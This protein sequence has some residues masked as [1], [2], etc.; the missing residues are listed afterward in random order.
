MKVLGILTPFVLIALAVVVVALMKRAKATA[1]STATTNVPAAPTKRRSWGWIGWVVAVLVVFW[2][3]GWYRSPKT[4]TSRL[5]PAQQ[6]ATTTFQRTPAPPTIYDPLING[7]A[8]KYGVPADLIRSVIQRESGFNPKAVSPKGAKGLMQLMD[9][10]AKTYGV[11][12]VF[13][14][15]QNIDAGVHHLS[16]LLKK[17]GQTEL[18]LATYNSNEDTVDRVRPRGSETFTQISAR[19]PDE[20]QKYV[21]AVMLAV[22]AYQ[23]GGF[24]LTVLAKIGEWSENVS[25]PPFHWAR[26]IPEGKIRI[27]IWNGQEIDDEPGKANWLGDDILNANFRFQSREGGDVKVTVLMRPK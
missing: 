25:V 5:R 15:T 18:A 17:Y 10:T 26:V 7:A 3:Y 21:P 4:P 22:G 13:D 24:A 12:E 20:T 27:R 9:N 8:Q 11:T 19:L 23:T 16:G 2:I 6:T 14:P 1:N